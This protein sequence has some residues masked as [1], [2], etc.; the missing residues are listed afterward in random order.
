MEGVSGNYTVFYDSNGYDLSVPADSITAMCITEAWESYSADL[1]TLIVRL[2]QFNE[3]ADGLQVYAASEYSAALK[4]V[5]KGVSGEQAQVLLDNLNVA[6]NAYE[7]LINGDKYTVTFNVFG[8]NSET[9][10]SFSLMLTDSY[11]NVSTSDSAKIQVIAG[12]YDFVVSS[13]FNRTE[14]RV[15]VEGDMS[16]DVTLPSNEW[17][18]RIR[19]RTANGTGDASQNN[20]THTVQLYVEDMTN[21]LSGTGLTLYVVSGSLPDTENTV[22]FKEYV[23]TQGQTVRSQVSWGSTTN[24]LAGLLDNSMVGNTAL[25]EAQ[26]VDANG[27][28]MV[29]SYYLEFIR[30]PTLSLLK[31]ADAQGVNYLS[32]F[33]PTTQSYSLTVP[34]GVYT[35]TGNPYSVQGCIV[36]VNGSE[37]ASDVTIMEGSNLVTVTVSH[38]NGQSRT[39]S[40]NVTGSKPSKVFFDVPGE[41]S[42]EVFTSAGSLLLPGTDG[43]YDLVAGNVYYYVATKE[44][45]YQTS[46]R[47]IAEEGLNVTVAEP[48]TSDRLEN[49]ALYNASSIAIRE[50]HAA[51]K[52]FNSADH[53]YSYVIEDAQVGLYA[54]ATVASGSGYKAFARYNLQFEYSSEPNSTLLNYPVDEN[55]AAVNLNRAVMASGYSQTIT[56]VLE[57]TDNGV[58]YT[59]KY[60]MKIARKVQLRALVPKLDG[61]NLLLYD[62]S[63]SSVISFD[64]EITSYC[65][66]VAGSTEEIVISGAFTNEYHNQLFGGGYSL[67]IGDQAYSDISD[68]VSV[69]IDSSQNEE[70]IVFTVSHV[71]SDAVP[72]TYTLKVVKFEPVSVSFDVT[73]QDATVFVLDDVT[74]KPI[75][76]QNGVYAM[77]PGRSYT[78]TVTKNG[79]VG[80]TGNYT[81][82]SSSDTVTVTLDASPEN[83][84][85]KDLDAEWPYF[86]ADTDNNGVVD[87]KTPVIAEDTVLYWATK[88]GEGWGA[89]AC[90]CP[91]LVDGYLYVYASTDIYKVDTVSGIVVA[92]GTMDRAS[93]FAINSPA[94]AEGMIFVGLSNGG[95]QAFNANTL[96]SLWIYNDPIKAQPNCSIVYHD[97][98]IYT[99]FWKGETMDASFVCLSVTDENPNSRTEEKLPTW[100]HVQKGGFYWAGA[101]VCDD[102]LLVG[103]DDGEAGYVTG[104]SQ[105]LSFDPKTGEMISS[106]T[107]PHV[108]DL[109]SSIAHDAVTGDYFFTTKGGYFYRLSV[110]ADGTIDDESLRYVKLD[111]YAD[112]PNNPPMSTCT[113]VI[114]NGRAYVGVSG[115]SQF[116][117][118]SG[119]NITVIDLN[120]MRIAYKVRTQGFPQTSGLL[121]TAYDEG[122]GTVYV[123]FVDNMTPGK[124]RVISDRPGQY[125]PKE[126]TQETFSDKTGTRVYDTAYVLFTPTGGQAEFAICSPIADSTGTIYFKN[127]SGCLM[128]MGPTIDRLEITSMPDKTVYDIGEKFDPNGMKVTAYYSNGTSRDITNYVSYSKEALD[129]DDTEF[130]IRFDYVMYQNYGDETGVPYDAPSVILDLTVGTVTPVILGD[131]NGD[132]SVTATDVTALIVLIS[133]NET[134][135]I[136]VGDINGD[137]SVTATDVTA[138]LQRIAANQ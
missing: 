137:G 79:F 109:R 4:G 55:G 50:K 110:N 112:D 97:G 6:I 47:F 38:E 104:Y 24:S 65:V 108:G 89:Q 62:E 103:T 93:S 33:S 107:L 58:T 67:Q 132:G 119:H 7:E 75:F 27:Y 95:I 111:N 86:R 91:I 121:T 39:Y 113:P 44:T 76:P 3:M 32:G 105:V 71:D 100:R 51:D 117:Q 30:I 74:S 126:I 59:Q 60:I 25:L 134:P 92:R 49:F 20:A 5:Q 63:G 73:P 122:D 70:F 54:Q 83:T 19:T 34:A 94:Y 99:G 82:T 57:K 88:A 40:L 36:N 48:D 138:L 69:P 120:S 1:I 135:P 42:L 129:T 96:E 72:T 18:G 52:T 37:N 29:Q 11:G 87:Y 125:E 101:Y 90:G 13:G 15:T 116:G 133:K 78:Y 21:N 53:Q 45:Y 43:G 128:A 98:Y 41:T 124:L 23:N 127:D 22:L 66:K 26:Y 131:I 35:V 68:G 118:Y 56:V 31:F 10:D 123:Y 61:S 77:E 9:I 14:G 84:A 16:V 46:Y 136:A 28:R 102:F 130:E 115:T 8:E 2:G 17:F 12:S 106:I 81:A 80:Q 64:R 114:N 85:L